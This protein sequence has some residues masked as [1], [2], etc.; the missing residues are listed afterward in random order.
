MA[1][2][3]GV[4]LIF[5]LNDLGPAYF[6]MGFSIVERMKWARV[7]CFTTHATAITFSLVIFIE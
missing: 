5:Y 7:I 1:Q 3:E 6:N 2:P 4:I